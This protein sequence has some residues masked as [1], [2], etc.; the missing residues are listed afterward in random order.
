MRQVLFLLLLCEGLSKFATTAPAS[1][2]SSFPI[3]ITGVSLFD[4]APRTWWK[5]FM[6]SFYAT[7]QQEMQGLTLKDHSS[8]ND[9][10]ICQPRIFA[11]LSKNNTKQLNEFNDGG[12]G[13]IHLLHWKNSTHRQASGM[14][15]Y[16][17]TY[18]G[19][20]MYTSPGYV[21]ISIYCPVFATNTKYQERHYCKSLRH[22][23]SNL[24]I[25]LFPSY[26]NHTSASVAAPPAI[27]PSVTTTPPMTTYLQGLFSMQQGQVVLPVLRKTHSSTATTAVPHGAAT[28]ESPPSNVKT[29]ETDMVVCTVQTFKNSMSGPQLYLFATYY[30]LI[31]FQVVIYDRYGRHVEFIKDLIESH[32]VIYHPFTAF[33]I[34]DPEKFTNETAQQEVT[35]HTYSHDCHI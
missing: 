15:C 26:I 28:S 16:Y 3:K 27:F 14:H 5:H 10:S 13:V 17:H 22:N 1:S 20:Y 6:P 18:F 2:I 34:R 23:P 7:H 9:G 21:G 8:W 12:F 19:T 29:E 32:G 31:G 4:Q 11:V 25:I 35:T 30:S 33:E 24:E